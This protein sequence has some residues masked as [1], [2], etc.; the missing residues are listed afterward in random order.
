M[1]FYTY[2]SFNY[3]PNSIRRFTHSR[4]FMSHGCEPRLSPNG[5]M[6]SPVC[7]FSPHSMRTGVISKPDFVFRRQS[8]VRYS[9]LLS[10][11]GKSYDLQ[12]NHQVPIY[13]LKQMISAGKLE[14]DYPVYWIKPLT[15]EG[16][17]IASTAPL[18]RRVKK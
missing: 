18:T 1:K 2:A 5:K 14:Y 13:S 12:F 6:L 9:L 11:R 8:L 10:C 4:S 17:D 16:L 7:C 3:G 15:E